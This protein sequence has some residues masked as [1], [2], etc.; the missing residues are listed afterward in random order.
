MANLVRV[1]QLMGRILSGLVD[2]LTLFSLALR[3]SSSLAAENL[4]LRKQLSL[5]VERKK[6]PRRASDRIRFTLVQLSK[7][8]QCEMR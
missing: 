3:P 4:F 6:K 7:H 5:Y 8:F 1:A 2:L